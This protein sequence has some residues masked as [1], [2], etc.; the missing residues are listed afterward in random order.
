MDRYTTINTFVDDAYKS[1][2][3]ENILNPLIVQHNKMGVDLMSTSDLLDRVD[4]RVDHLTSTKVSSLFDLNDIPVKDPGKFLKVSASGNLA[5]EAVISGGG[6]GDVNLTP[7]TSRLNVIEPK[8]ST[9]ESKVSTLE[10][11]VSTLDLNVT[12]H[13]GRISALESSGGGSGGGSSTFTGLTDTPST[14]VANKWLKVNSSGSALEFTSEPSGSGGGE[15]GSTTFTALTDTPS[16]YTGSAGKGLRVNTAG[17]GVE[18]YS[19]PS[20][21]G[22]SLIHG[23]DV[24][25]CMCPVQSVYTAADCAEYCTIVGATG[26]T[27]TVALPTIIET[28]IDAEQVPGGRLLF[29]ASLKP[30]MTITPVERQKIWYNGVANDNL[31]LAAGESVQLLSLQN[32]TAFI[33]WV[34]VSGGATSFLNHPA[35]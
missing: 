17:N 5:W 29:I 28:P 6:G 34:A 30:A 32:G 1:H 26:N 12:N 19:M 4:D 7:I 9:L 2:I 27:N 31:T 13:S 21:G 20:I 23:K 16:D 15:G 33:H 3:R 8:V 35:A 11:K 22:D 14:L 18:F 10:P 24:K 25:F